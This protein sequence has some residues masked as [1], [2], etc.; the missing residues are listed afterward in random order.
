V[1]EP[2]VEVKPLLLISIPVEITAALCRQ[3]GPTLQLAGTNDGN[4]HQIDGARLLWAISGCESK[5]GKNCKPRFESAYY[6]DGLYYGK[7]EK[8]QQLVAVYGRDAAC[9]YGPWQILAVNAKHSPEVLGADPN[10][11]CADAAQFINSFCVRERKCRTLT[12]F[13]DCYNTGNP[14]D[15]NVPHRYIH[16]LIDYYQN[17]PIPGE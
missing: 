7:S 17:Y 3:Y 10:A 16:D 8:L 9:S 12:D 15:A 13:A 14:H 4:G 1:D 6:L 11:A 2:R 5:F